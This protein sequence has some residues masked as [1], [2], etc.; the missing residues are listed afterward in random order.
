MTLKPLS[1]CILV[2]QDLE[3]LSSI[4]VTPQDKLFS[5]KV[6]AAGPGK[7]LLK[8][9]VEP[10]DVKVGDHIMFGEF[11]GQTVTFDHKDYLM[12]RVKDVIGI[13]E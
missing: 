8:G 7:Q 4:I 5:G 1:D 3:K 11:S 6:I 9:G 2:E 10:M 12:M 13:I